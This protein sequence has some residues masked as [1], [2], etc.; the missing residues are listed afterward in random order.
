M[1]KR[2]Y[3]E[4]L[5]ISRNASEGELKKAYRKLAMKYHPD[6]NP[7]DHQTEEKFKEIQEAYSALSDQQQRAAYDQFGHAGM[8]AGARGGFNFNDV[9][10]DIGDIFGDIFGG[11]RGGPGHSQAQRGADLRYNLE[12]SL[13]NAVHGTSVQIRIPTL[14]SCDECHGSGSKAGSKPS[15]CKTCDGVG[16]VRIQQGFFTIQQTCPTCHGEGRVITDPCKKC[17]GQGRIQHSK[18]LSVKIPAG[19]DEGDRIRLTGEGE[20]GVHGAPSGDLYVQASIKEH[21]LFKREGQ[22]LYVEVPVS[23]M[24]AVLGGEIQIPTLE[25]PVNLHIPTETQSGKVLRL[26]GR[27]LKGMRG[28]VAGDLFCKIM[29][30]TPV[31][32]SAKQKTMLRELQENLTGEH[33]TEHHPRFHNWLEQA[34][35]FFEAGKHQQ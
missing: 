31:N 24:T 11:R 17:R 25:G 35:H 19:I 13:E 10:G 16:Q 7:G 5:G 1:S 18:T 12:L 3:Y 4:I 6:R 26:R 14:T 2:D 9:F 21:Q 28:G 22:H 8:G 32:L 34:K 23:F 30:E 20:A 15:T 33:K 27:G 29:V